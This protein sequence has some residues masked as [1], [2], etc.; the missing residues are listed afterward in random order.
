MKNLKENFGRY[1]EKKELSREKVELEDGK[2]CDLVSYNVKD[3][4]FAEYAENIEVSNGDFRRSRS[5]I[6]FDCIDACMN[7]FLWD[8]YDSDTTIPKRIAESFITH[9][10]EY[11]K[12]GRGLYIFSKTK[13]SGKTFLACAMANEIIKDKD[14][15]VKFILVPELLDMTKKSYRDF[16][17][18][19]DLDRIKDAELLI[20]DD[21]GAETK[22]EWVD[23]ELFRLIDYRY[24]N[25]KITIFTSNV[26]M[27]MLKL[28]DR[29]IDRIYGRNLRLPLPEKSVRSMQ[30][31]EENIKFMQNILK[32][33]P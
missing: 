20:L 9:F 10:Y 33:A 17:R 8:I 23:T 13:G 16:A 2:M 5:M 6:P 29:I 7:K 26:E 14:I 1:S 30:A 31:D 3:Y 11:Q 19:D 18:E 12:S 4:G 25:K 21:I 32:N 27:D 15:C 28:N 24:S 22:K